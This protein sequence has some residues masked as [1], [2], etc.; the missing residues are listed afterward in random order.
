[1]KSQSDDFRYLIYTVFHPFDGFYELRFRRKRNWVLIAAIYILYGILSILNQYYSG[2]LVTEDSYQ[3]N[4]WF[5]F[6]SSLFPF[7]LFAVANWSITTLFD[8]NGSLGDVLMVLAYALAPK[9]LLDILYIILSNFVVNEELVIINVVHGFGVFLLCFLTF[10]GLCVVHE[11]M[12][13]KNVVTIIATAASAAVITF[14]GMLYL[15]MMGKIIGFIST[16]ALE[17][18]KRV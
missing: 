12:A 17:L 7:F 5:L 11:Y 4:N 3:T 15:Q 2:F 16:V 10:V 18:L 1:M 8:G 6:L 14:I 9:I 13:A